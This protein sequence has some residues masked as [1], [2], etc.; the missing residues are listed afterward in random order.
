MAHKN[1]DPRGIGRNA[2]LNVGRLDRSNRHVATLTEADK[3]LA[4]LR[5]V[6][7]SITLD[8][9]QLERSGAGDAAI[10]DGEISFVHQAFSHEAGDHTVGIGR[11]D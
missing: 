9:N 6:L 7:T 2:A 1:P 11:S 8:A 5:A 4:S 3:A 10:A